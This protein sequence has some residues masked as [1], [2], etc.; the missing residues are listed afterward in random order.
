VAG[1]YTETTRLP[2]CCQSFPITFLIEIC[3]LKTLGRS[4][5]AFRAPGQS[6]NRR[7]RCRGARWGGYGFGF[8]WRGLPLVLLPQDRGKERIGWDF[9]ENMFVSV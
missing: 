2:N 6:P 9:G 7:A 4:Y 5:C 3:Q 1:N 8:L